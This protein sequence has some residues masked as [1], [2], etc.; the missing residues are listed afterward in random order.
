MFVQF[1][2]AVVG[3]HVLIAASGGT[4]TVDIRKSCHGSESAVIAVLG[5]T[6]PIT[7]ENCL[8]QEQAA[9]EQLVKD[10]ASY[11][12]VDRKLCVQ[13]A[14]YMPSYVEWLICLE[15]GRDVRKIKTEQPSST[16]PSGATRGH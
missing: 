4:P 13:P 2:P 16:L 6:T 5:N 11:P 8:R 10:W 15:M 9:R 7:F 14:S 12:D 1:G 3:L